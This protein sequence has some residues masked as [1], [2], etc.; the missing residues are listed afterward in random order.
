MAI[1]KNTSNSKYWWGCRRKVLPTLPLPG[2]DSK[3]LKTAYFRDVATSEFM[4]AQFKIER[5]SNEA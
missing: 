5:L 1:I 2:I 4:A 3:D